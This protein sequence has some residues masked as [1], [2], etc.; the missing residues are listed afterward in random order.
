VLSPSLEPW[1]DDVAAEVPMAGVVLD[2]HAVSVCCSVRISA[3]ADEAGVETHADFRGRGYALAAVAAWSEAV[4]SLGRIPLYS[5]SW[6]NAASRQVAAKLG[7]IQY[8]SVVHI[9]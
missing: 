5:T 8:G 6:D 1:L 9:T 7:L 4:R 3:A 2:G